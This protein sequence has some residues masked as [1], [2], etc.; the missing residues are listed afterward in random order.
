MKK[1]SNSKYQDS[2][3]EMNIQRALRTGGFLFPENVDE[4]EEYE[5]LYGNT[6]FILPEELQEPVFLDT[7][8]SEDIIFPDTTNTV[9]VTMAARDGKNFIPEHIKEKMKQE[10]DIARSKKNKK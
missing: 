5:L 7:K 1:Q 4:V 8:K 6:D 9:R 2:Q 10:R 3:K